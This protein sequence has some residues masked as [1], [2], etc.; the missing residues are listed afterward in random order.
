DVNL[1]TLGHESEHALIR[2]L[3]EYPDLIAESARLRAPYRLT[4]YL[5]VLAG[6][7]NGGFYRDCRVMTDD[8]ELTQARLWLVEATRQVMANALEILGVN[9]PD[10]M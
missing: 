5:Q 3:N 9:A 2:K 8:L 6:L 4:T 10:R 1:A 7:F